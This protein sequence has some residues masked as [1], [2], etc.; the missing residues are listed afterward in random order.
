[1]ID[2]SVLSLFILPYLI[3]ALTLLIHRIDNNFKKK[4]KKNVGYYL[5][6]K[7]LKWKRLLLLHKWYYQL[8]HTTYLKAFLESCFTC[9]SICTMVKIFKNNFIILMIFSIVKKKKNLFI[10]EK[11]KPIMNFNVIRLCVNQK[12]YK[13]QPE[14]WQQ[15]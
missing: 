12:L 3:S 6:L 14:R 11:K 7:K 4:K 9:I 8:L 1:M 2:C 10:K 5:W 15:G 13:C